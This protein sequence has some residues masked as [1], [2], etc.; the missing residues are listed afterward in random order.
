LIAPPTSDAPKT[1]NSWLAAMPLLAAL[2]GFYLPW[3]NNA[4]AALSANAFDLAEWVGLSPAQRSA[5]PPMLAPF[6]LRAGLAGLALLFG[7]RARAAS[8]GPARLAWTGLALVLALILL[9]PLE[10]FRGAWDDVNYRQLMGLCLGALIG[11]G[12]IACLRRRQLPWRNLEILV[13]ALSMLC[14]LLGEL[15]ALN[16]VRALH[17]PAPLGIGGPVFAISLFVHR[18]WL[19][20]PRREQQNAQTARD[21]HTSE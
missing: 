16:V 19:V 5:N 20:P 1:S 15:Q 21:Q 7:L 4:A 2:I 9:P 14:A 13:T 11:L 3:L 6:L 10:F 18:L 8:S 12:L 17:I